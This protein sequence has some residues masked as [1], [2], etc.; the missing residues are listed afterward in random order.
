MGKEHAIRAL[1]SGKYHKRLVDEFEGVTR[2]EFQAAYEKRDNDTLKRSVLTN[3]V[4]FL[5]RM[6]KDSLLAA[7]I[8]ERVEK[9][10]F[11]VNVYPYDFSDQGLVDMLVACIRFH[12]YSTS[13]V[14]IVSIPNEELTP[15]FCR[16]NYQ[17]MIRY[18]W[19]RW[20]DKHKTFFEKEGIPGVSLVVPEL[21]FE[22]APSQDDIDRL[23]MKKKNPFTQ[24]EAIVAALFR[25][26]HM[27][28]SLF[29]V[30]ESLTKKDTAEHLARVQVTQED[31][32]EYLNKSHP[33]A[34]LIRENPLPE[35]D[36][37][38]AFELL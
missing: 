22:T 25:L 4:F 26:K 38:D 17:I 29:S 3:L 37:D 9:M 33:K 30:H 27:P 12:T 7:I 21:F 11:T 31:I 15:Q 16:E 36:I 1:N 19:V 34:T 2:E 8:H 24:T 6:V 20:A 10:C 32:E 23:D 35:V 14:Q 13:S 5:R 18:D 28:A